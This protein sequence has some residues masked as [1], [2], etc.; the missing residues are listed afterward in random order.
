MQNIKVELHQM[1]DRIEDN[2]VL[3][4]VFTLLA[5]Q[6]VAYTTDQKPLNQRDFEAMI[7]EG[8]NDFRNGKT[9]NQEEIKAHFESKMN[10]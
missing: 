6:P 5:N 2:K 4:A 7:D 1:I 3:E 9:Y 8:E 10:G